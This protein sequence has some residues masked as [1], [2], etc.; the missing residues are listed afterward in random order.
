MAF[1]LLDVQTAGGIASFRINRPQALNALNP[2]VV[3]Q[4]HEALR[5]AMAAEDVRG[6]VIGGVGK[7]FAAGADVEFFLRNLAAGDIARIVQFTAAGHALLEDIERAAKPVVASVHG[8]ALG[9]G[10]ELAL[11][12]HRILVAPPATLGL[13]ETSLGLY[14]GLG[15]TYR[16]P[17]RIGPGLAKWLIY[18][19][20]IL[21]AAEARD[22][23]LADDLVAEA[24]L[25][26]AARECILS[27]RPAPRRPQPSAEI[28]SL[29]AFF[30]SHSVAE[31]L[32][33]RADAQGNPRLLGALR[34]VRANAPVALRLAER[35]IDEAE[36]RPAAEAMQLVLDRLPELFAT[37]DAYG[38]LSAAGKRQPAFRGC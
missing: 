13:P 5:Q 2:A 23:G 22:I 9:G 10:L 7:A 18:T 17:R 15:G 31:L 37:R 35:L 11:A 38:G 24:D 1:S 8:L 12:C 27:S 33:D 28:L 14:P 25:A 32:A 30:Q 4:L 34:R 3:F 29:G 36:K 20:K 6:V 26:A 21:S 16:L 19:G